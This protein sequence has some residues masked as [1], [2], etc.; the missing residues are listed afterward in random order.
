[1]KA[2]LISFIKKLRI[3][4]F[5]KLNFYDYRKH[6]KEYW[7]YAS[8]GVALAAEATGK[9]R[10]AVRMDMIIK[11]Y[12]TLASFQDYFR[13]EFYLRSLEN[14]NEYLTKGKYSQVFDSLS[15]KETIEIMDNK[16]LFLDVFKDYVGR[17]WLHVTPETTP[18]D[19][20][21]FTGKHKVF[22]GK[23]ENLNMGRG[24][25]L[26]NSEDF[27]GAEELLDHLL[28]YE[29]FLIEERLENHE[30]LK[31]FSKVSLNT[32]RVIT[33]KHSGGAKIIGVLFKFGDGDNV[34]DS[35]GAGYKCPVDIE[36]GVIYRGVTGSGALRNGFLEKHPDG[37]DII[38]LTIPFWEEL[39]VMIKDAA[40][41][42]EDCYYVPWD[43]AVTPD[44]P[45]I[46][47]GNCNCGYDYQWTTGR[48]TYYDMKEAY[49]FAE[50]SR[51]K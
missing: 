37:Y 5:V 33:V 4:H 27:S 18:A 1:M 9:S 29:L 36:T 24:I 11:S 6:L 34:A 3:A 48:P 42:L 41:L 43:V 46:V 26:I 23:R 35:P 15:T 39:V 40:M 20:E 28:K 45:Q 21:K 10:S 12:L 13:F 8:Q 16:P 22:I 47:E 19:I 50:A 7:R 44:G 14:A 2:L 49:D 17:D 38:G 32:L 25:Q 30:D 31:K 51:K